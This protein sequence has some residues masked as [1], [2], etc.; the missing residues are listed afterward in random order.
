MFKRQHLSLIL[1]LCMGLFSFS[2]CKKKGAKSAADAQNQ[3]EQAAIDES[4]VVEEA[5]VVEQSILD[6]LPIIYFEFEQALLSEASRATLQE[7]ATAMSANS[8]ASISIEGHCDQRGSNEYNLALGERRA[9]SVQKYLQNLGV[10]AT[11]M[12]V[13][14]FGE[15]RPKNSGENEAAWSQNR[16]AE[17]TVSR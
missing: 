1:C 10:A 5:P 16:R 3:A 15:E 4:A 2:S 12:T 14:S 17:F 13:T 7:I 11:R 9:R 6:T 8:T